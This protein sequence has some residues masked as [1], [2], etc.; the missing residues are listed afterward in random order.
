MQ[1]RIDNF[2]SDDDLGATADFL[3]DGMGAH[4]PN[5]HLVHQQSGLLSPESDEIE[6]IEEEPLDT[7]NEMEHTNG[8]DVPTTYDPFLPSTIRDNG[9]NADTDNKGNI[10]SEIETHYDMMPP[11][12]TTAVPSAVIVPS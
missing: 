8:A 11:I 7:S 3:D 2:L 9:N 6:E 1:R 4:I 12:H 10:A 5:P